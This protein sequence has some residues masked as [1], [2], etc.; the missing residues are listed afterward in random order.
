MTS[1]HTHIKGGITEDCWSGASRVACNEVL[2]FTLLNEEGL[3]AGLVGGGL[4]LVLGHLTIEQSCSGG[5]RIERFCWHSRILKPAEHIRTVQSQALF[6]RCRD[7]TTLKKSSVL[8]QNMPLFRRA[9]PTCR[10]QAG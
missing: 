1:D 6:R 8:R 7:K 2:S 10:G 4:P 9:W 5:R 3:S